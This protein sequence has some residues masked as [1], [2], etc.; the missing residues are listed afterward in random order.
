MKTPTPINFVLR[1]GTKKKKKK[2]NQFR[3]FFFV[4]RSINLLSLCTL[5]VQTNVYTSRKRKEEKKKKNNLVGNRNTIYY[6]INLKI[7]MGRYG[8]DVIFRYY[9][10]FV[11]KLRLSR[12]LSFVE[13]KIAMM[14]SLCLC[15]SSSPS[16]FLEI[17]TRIYYIRGRLVVR[18]WVLIISSLL[19]E[20]SIIRKPCTKVSAGLR[21][22]FVTAIS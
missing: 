5:K 15:L 20:R 17:Y 1:L 9:D 13:F 4:N 14:S 3:I 21:E 22:M 18:R 7:S 16:L 8:D 6:G 19:N 11:P 12:I 2:L 10:K